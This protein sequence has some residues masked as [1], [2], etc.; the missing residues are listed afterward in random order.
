VKGV[1]KVKD[2]FYRS[3]YVWGEEASGFE[4][5]QY[6]LAGILAFVALYTFM[7]LFSWVITGF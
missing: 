1:L 7:V 2:L 5:A 3:Y 6:V 4:L